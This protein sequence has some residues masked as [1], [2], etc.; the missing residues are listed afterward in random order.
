MSEKKQQDTRKS[1]I[2][3]EVTRLCSYYKGIAATSRSLNRGLIQRAAF[4]RVMLEEIEEDLNENGYTEMF[5]QSANQEP[6]ERKRPA[7]DLYNTMNSNY[8]KIMKQL[9]DL[10]PKEP[11]K[12]KGKD[13]EVEDGFDGFV[14]GRED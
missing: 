10:L 13:E 14:N 6:Y 5:S 7:A 3:K 11:A 12:E 1:K 2:E 9:T 4:M 8:Q